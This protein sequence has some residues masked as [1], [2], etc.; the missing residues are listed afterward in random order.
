MQK[1][2]IKQ[3]VRKQILSYF[4]HFQCNALKPK[5]KTTSYQQERSDTAQVDY[6]LDT[7]MSVPALNILDRFFL[8]SKFH[9]RFSKEL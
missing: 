7:G 9:L 5:N 3:D 6:G 2:V 1:Q 4:K 8:D